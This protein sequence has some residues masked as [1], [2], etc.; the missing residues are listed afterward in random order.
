MGELKQLAV[1]TEN[2]FLSCCCERVPTGEL[3]LQ[4]QSR[5]GCLGISCVPNLTSTTLI[6]IVGEHLQ[7]QLKSLRARLCKCSIQ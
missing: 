4:R 1:N 6:Y 3:P 5:I 7:Q 2:S